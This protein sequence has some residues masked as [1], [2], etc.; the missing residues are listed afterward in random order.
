MTTTEPLRTRRWHREGIGRGVLTADFADGTDSRG[1]IA[2]GDADRG[3]SALPPQPERGCV[4][5]TSRSNVR[6]RDA[7]K[8]PIVMQCRGCCQGTTRRIDLPPA[9]ET[10]R[11]ALWSA[12]DL[13]P[14]SSLGRLVAQA[15]PRRCGSGNDFPLQH[16]PM[17][18]IGR[19]DG[20]QGLT[21]PE[22]VAKSSACTFPEP[23]PRG[24]ASA[25]SR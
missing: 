18:A 13:S 17:G 4:A 23:L 8:L 20:R 9:H 14:L 21:T 2:S 6:Y 3:A 22:S 5:A 1:G 7:W 25:T 15:E 12:C 16:I 11:A 10:T 24:S 19:G